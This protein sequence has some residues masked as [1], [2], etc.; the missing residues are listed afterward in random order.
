VSALAAGRRVCRRC[1]SVAVG[2]VVV[3]QPPA[4]SVNTNAC[5]P[6]LASGAPTTTFDPSTAT[7]VPKSVSLPGAD[8]SAAGYIVLTQP[9]CGSVK[10]YA[11]PGS[12]LPLSALPYSAP[13]TIV[14]PEIATDV[15]NAADWMMPFG[16]SVAVWVALAQPPLGGIVNTYTSPTPVPL[17]PWFGAPMTIVGPSTATEYPK[18]SFA[19]PSDADSFASWLKVGSIRSG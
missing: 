15:P 18:L 10:T 8:S 5:P 19:S 17:T 2:A 7:D 3:V 13:T 6:P 11:D 4:G 1:W 14:V 16:F 12:L 9:P